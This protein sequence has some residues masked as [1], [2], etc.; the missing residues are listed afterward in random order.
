LKDAI[1]LARRHRRASVGALAALL[2]LLTALL[3]ERTS[4]PIPP[5]GPIPVPVSDAPSIHGDVSDENVATSNGDVHIRTVDG[6]YYDFQLVGEFV[7]M[8]SRAGDFEIQVRLGP[9]AGNSRS[10]ST[11]TAVALNVAGDRVGVYTRKNPSVLVNGA[12]TALNDQPL[13]LRNGG[14]I[15]ANGG[16]I[17]VLWPDG[18]KARIVLLG[19]YLNLFISLA[20][21][22]AGTISG[23]FGNFDGNAGNDLIMR[24]GKL[25][26]IVDA[27]ASVPGTQAVSL[28]RLFGD[29]WR[30]EAAESLFDYG[31]GESTVTFTDRNFPY[32]DIQVDGA[33]RAQAEQLCRDA[34][35]VDARLM[36]NCILDVVA[37][38]D[39]SFIQS[40]MQVQAEVKLEKGIHCTT[41]AGS[42]SRCSFYEPDLPD[43][44]VGTVVHIKIETN[45]GGTHDL[46]AFECT[47]V[48]AAHRA[49]CKF[50]TNG[51][52]FAGS[53]LSLS[54]TSVNGD[55]RQLSGVMQSQ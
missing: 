26:N 46:E 27:T 9:W 8:R 13:A 4:Q 30:I 20:Q 34:R 42:G 33:A 16:T 39:A 37:T 36:A 48:D 22:R 44:K 21:R 31:S 17:A 47:E 50:E 28:Y 43:G 54:Y 14:R 38:G 41:A 52:V 40:A 18:S 23:L 49:S 10:V 32:R 6:L 51:E 45:R 35:V 7:A 12:P 1:S 25:L 3:F 19:D 5:A 53:T 11:N 55:D 24:D 2:A 29:G 15:T